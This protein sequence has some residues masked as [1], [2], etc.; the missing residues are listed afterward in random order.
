MKNALHWSTTGYCTASVWH[1][2][3]NTNAMGL[4]LYRC[5]PSNHICFL[6]HT[7]K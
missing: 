3:F 4:V 5:I 2:A 6:Y 7:V 1:K